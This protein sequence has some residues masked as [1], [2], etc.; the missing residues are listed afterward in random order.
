MFTVNPYFLTLQLHSSLILINFP[1]VW[2]YRKYTLN[3][4]IIILVISF[5]LWYVIIVSIIKND[6]TACRTFYIYRLWYYVGNRNVKSASYWLNVLSWPVQKDAFT[7]YN[8]KKNINVSS[9]R[10]MYFK[11]ITDLLE[12]I[13][14]RL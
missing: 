3:L 7:K 9:K 11:K 1:K 4:W 10:Y 6:M 13:K 12:L 2:F 5:L 8:F 14:C